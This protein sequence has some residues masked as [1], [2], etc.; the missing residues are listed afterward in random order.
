MSHSDMLSFRGH[1]LISLQISE[2][3]GTAPSQAGEWN[4]HLQTKM[5]TCCRRPLFSL[6]LV[7]KCANVIT[8]VF[9]IM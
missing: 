3:W 4:S 8:T 5:T 1:Q 6:V 9:I 2:F 7:C